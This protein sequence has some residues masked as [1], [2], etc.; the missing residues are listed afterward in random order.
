MTITIMVDLYYVNTLDWSI[1]DYYHYGR[2]LLRQ[3]TQ[4]KYLW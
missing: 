3:Y 2:S 1:Y 4:L